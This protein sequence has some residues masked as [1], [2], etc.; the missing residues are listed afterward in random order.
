MM[1]VPRRGCPLAPGVAAA[2][3]KRRFIAV[4]QPIV[5]PK[6]GKNALVNDC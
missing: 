5:L 3:C 1:S 6:S 4:F 2:L